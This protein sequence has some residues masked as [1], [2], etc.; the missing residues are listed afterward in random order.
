[1]RNIFSVSAKILRGFKQIEAVYIYGSALKNRNF[2]DIDFALITS[3][4]IKDEQKFI[5]DVSLSLEAELKEECDVHLMR[6]FP[7]HL[8]YRI[9]SEGKLLFSKDEKETTWFEAE[10]LNI[11]LDFKPTYDW[12]NAQIINRA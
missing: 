12:F 9:I 7:M 10:V 6:E 5:T 11:F 1:M 8:K 4:K 3:G 2:E